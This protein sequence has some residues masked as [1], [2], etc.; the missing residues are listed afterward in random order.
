MMRAG[1]RKSRLAVVQAQYVMD[2]LCAVWPDTSMTL[3]TF[4]THG[5]K[6]LGTALHQVGEKGLFVKELEQALLAGE[7]DMAVHSMKDMPAQQPEELLLL[8]FGPRGNPADALISRSGARLDDLPAGSVIGTS[9]LRRSA[10]L[11]EHRPDLRLIVMRGNVETRLQKL[12]EGVCDAIILAAAGLHRL[13]LAHRVTQTF[14]PME[15]MVPAPC[16]GTLA[17]EFARPDMMAALAPFVDPQTA[18]CTRAERA[19]LKALNAGCQTPM[20]AYAYP[21]PSEKERYGMRAMLSKAE[22]TSLLWTTVLFS[23][24]DAE[25]AGRQ[26]AQTLLAEGD[27][28]GVE[29]LL[30]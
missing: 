15:D 21:I 29:V 8:P 19:F 5:D 18:V 2:T 12:D 25:H 13:S 11:H 1:S 24:A 4:V 3:E 10:W 20:G 17:I 27:T 6:V 30:G 22:R 16:Q 14:S 26:A 9:S 23:P 28:E 7:I